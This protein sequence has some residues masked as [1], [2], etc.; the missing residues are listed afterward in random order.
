LTVLIGQYDVRNL[1]P[2]LRPR[3]ALLLHHLGMM[4][5]LIAPLVMHVIATHCPVLAGRDRRRGHQTTRDGDNRHPV[6]QPETTTEH[7]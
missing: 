1:V 5:V 7:Y 2:M 3:V 6:R 4:R